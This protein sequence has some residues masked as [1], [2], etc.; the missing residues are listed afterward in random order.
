M[1]SFRKR[2]DNWEYRIIY[3]DPITNKRREK[4]QKGFR[5]KRYQVIAAEIERNL[6]LGKHNLIHN[7]ERIVKDWL[8]EWLQV[9]GS[10]CEQKL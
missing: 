7:K 9:Y 4:T 6:F 2:G 10:Q 1:A 5:T 3:K 8:E